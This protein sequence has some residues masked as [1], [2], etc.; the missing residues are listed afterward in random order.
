MTKIAVLKVALTRPS[1]RGR[2]C[3][4]ERWRTMAEE[5]MIDIRALFL[6][7]ENMNDESENTLKMRRGRSVTEGTKEG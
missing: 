1:G 2:H 5:Y 4:H 6:L 3:H 7:L